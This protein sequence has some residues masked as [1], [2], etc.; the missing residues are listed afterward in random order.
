MRGSFPGA[1]IPPAAAPAHPALHTRHDTLAIRMATRGQRLHMSGMGCGVRNKL[2]HLS[3]LRHPPFRHSPRHHSI[4]EAVTKAK[5]WAGFDF[6]SGFAVSSS[7]RTVSATRLINFSVIGI[8][9]A[10]LILVVQGQWD[11]DESWAYDPML[12]IETSE[13]GGTLIALSVPGLKPLF[14]KLFSSPGSGTNAS[15]TF[16]S[17]AHGGASKSLYK[18]NGMGDFGWTIQG[19]EEDGKLSK[20]TEDTKSTDVILR[21]V[22]FVVEDQDLDERALK[23]RPVSSSLK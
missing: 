12:A 22:Q 18:A 3:A 21:D 15:S 20:D 5:D 2:G 9:I 19:G 6:L 16:Q 17:G 1:C 10:R 7:F 11:A 14:D 8:S 13:I 23:P 4:H